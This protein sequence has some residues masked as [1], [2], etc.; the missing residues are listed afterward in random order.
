M[1]KYPVVNLPAEFEV[2]TVDLLITTTAANPPRH[3][4]N[5]AAAGIAQAEFMLA[6]AEHAAAPRSN[7][8][9]TRRLMTS[10]IKSGTQ[11][12]E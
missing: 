1:F 4:A 3:I 6:K 5:A 7:M 10:V 9:N 8:T 12:A 2:C 11:T